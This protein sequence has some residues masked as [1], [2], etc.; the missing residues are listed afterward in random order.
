MQ[1]HDFDKSHE[2]VTVGQFETGH[3]SHRLTQLQN[4]GILVVLGSQSKV[5]LVAEF[6]QIL[7]DCAYIVEG[8]LLVERNEIISSQ[9]FVFSGAVRQDFVNSF[10]IGL[11]MAS[12][13]SD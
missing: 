3:L 12:D 13:A 2:V 7:P 11:N 1:V 8:T 9:F 10:V 5:G 4:V 6:L